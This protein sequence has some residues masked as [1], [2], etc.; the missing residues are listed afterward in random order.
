M[1]S[2]S[3][4]GTYRSRYTP[5]EG[6]LLTRLRIFIVMRW[7]AIA[8]VV[9]A[10][11][12]A[13][14]V[15]HIGFPTVPVYIICGFMLAYNL[16]F[17]FQSKGLEKQQSGTVIRRARINANIHLVLDL[18]M[19]SVLIHFTGGIE[20]P[21]IV[22]FAFPTIVTSIVLSRKGTYVLTTCALAMVSLLVGLEY[23]GW[24]PH[25]NL[26]GFA[27]PTLHQ[28][29][30]YVL[31][32][33]AALATLLYGA[34]YIT[35]TISGELKK[36]QRQVLILSAQLLKKKTAE[37][38]KASKEAAREREMQDKL[39]AAY[40]D[41]SE[42]LKQLKESQEHLIQ[43]EKLTS[44]GQMA[45]SIAHEINNPLSGVLTYTKLLIKQID[46]NRY[47]KENALVYLGKI[48]QAVTYSSKLVGNLLDFSRQSPPKFWELNVNE[49]VERSLDLTIHSAE[50]QHVKITKELAALPIIMADFDQ[51]QQVFTNLFMNAIQAM[52]NGG[53]LT[54][55]TSAD[56]D[57]IK[58]E[59][60]DTGVG[61]SAENIRNL[62]TP[63]F[64]TKK[65]TKGVGLGLAV[66]HGIVQRH[67]GS[68]DVK[69]EVGKGST[70]TVLLPVKALSG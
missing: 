2:D 29:G 8:G 63:F 31:P 13:S 70:F 62:F 36:R 18:V 48:E 16:V 65:E 3:S 40:K 6:A 14:K 47:S 22:Y 49:V 44:L 38:E 23:A 4:I 27:D 21:F 25:Y 26:Q 46:D 7:I 24:I 39:S 1:D 64:T 35:S 42:S 60:Q 52:P 59:V 37:L 32:G 50:L 68:I 43:A 41:L 51:L 10:T 61:I 15:F 66:S 28:K 69:S 11:L 12:V 19:L 55:R 17:L 5:E 54:I 53:E 34:T 9:I 67:N 45:A 57:H 33:L 30:T 20:N 58:T 56:G